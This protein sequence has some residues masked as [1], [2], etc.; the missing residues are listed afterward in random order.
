M[1]LAMAHI[2][3]LFRVHFIFIKFAS[4]RLSSTNCSTVDMLQ[5]YSFATMWMLRVGMREKHLRSRMQ[6]IKLLCCQMIQLLGYAIGIIGAY[7]YYS[8]RYIQR[9][10]KKTEENQMKIVKSF[11]CSYCRFWFYVDVAQIHQITSRY[12]YCVIRLSS[13]AHM[14][15]SAHAYVCVLARNEEIIFRA[16][17]HRIGQF[18]GKR[19]KIFAS[20]THT[21]ELA[22]DLF[23]S[24][25]NAE[26]ALK[27][28][29]IQEIHS[30]RSYAAQFL[31]PNYSN[32]KC[33]SPFNGCQMDLNLANVKCMNEM[34]CTTRSQ[35]LL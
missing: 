16:T 31:G 1:W 25:K 8:Y 35:S 24:P 17:I 29:V 13:L 19:L 4:V 26:H 20:V 27:I 3:G 10:A 28:D 22:R 21:D 14:T 23:R 6:C 33:Q 2:S 7:V 9:Y 5:N 12:S 15:I 30:N 34:C 11:F 32:W 18:I